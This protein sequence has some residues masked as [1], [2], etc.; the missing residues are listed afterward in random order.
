MDRSQVPARV[1]AKV[2]L[3]VAAVVAALYF[4]YLI[5][6]VIGLVFVAAFL[7]IAITPAVNWLNRRRVPR[8]LAILLVYLSIG[9]S[10]FGIAR[11]SAAL[12]PEMWPT[13]RSSPP[14]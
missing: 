1:V 14:S 10:I 2:V 9:A 11:F 3:I 8:S 5:R 13:G 7:A 4:A 12:K 6:D